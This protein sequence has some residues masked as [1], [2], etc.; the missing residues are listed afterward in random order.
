MHYIC[1]LYVG[2]RAL[3]T[4]LL[5]RLSWAYKAGVTGNISEMVDDRATATING[6]YKGVHWLS[7]DAEMYDLE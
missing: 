4:Y 5:T 7:I 6:L 2:T 3:L 1:Q